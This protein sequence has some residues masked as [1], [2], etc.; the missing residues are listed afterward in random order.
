M[1]GTAAR[2]RLIWERLVRRARKGT[3][4]QGDAPAR[5]GIFR[6]VV[7]AG[8][9]FMVVL[10]GGGGLWLTRR[11]TSPDEPGLSVLLITVDTLRADAVG[12]Y[13]K[14][15]AGTP[16]MDRLSDAGVRF[17]DAHAHNV[18]TLASHAN[19]LSGRYPT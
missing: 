5:R 19:I 15:D 12:A 4:A 14:A 16:W 13:G 3:V 17:E 18:V 10:G 7:A 6:V 11:G 8:V 9:F 1:G 2:S